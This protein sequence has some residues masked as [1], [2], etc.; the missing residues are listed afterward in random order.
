MGSELIAN[1]DFAS[2]TD[3]WGVTLYSI[4]E[5]SEELILVSAGAG[6]GHYYG[7]TKAGFGFSITSGQSYQVTFDFTLNSGTAPRVRIMQNS[8]EGTQRV[9]LYAEDTI[10]TGN[11]VAEFVGTHTETEYLSFF[12]HEDNASNFTIDNVSL[13]EITN[14]SGEALLQNTEQFHSLTSKSD[15]IYA[16][17]ERQIYESADGST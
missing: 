11:I 9:E 10:T 6:G 12:N 14:F 13:K 15:K 3:A 17:S 2:G 8:Y 16:A 1:G 4:N 5:T 7:G